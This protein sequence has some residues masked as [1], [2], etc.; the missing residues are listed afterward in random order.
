VHLLKEFAEIAKSFVVK[1]LFALY[2][3]QNHATNNDKV[4]PIWA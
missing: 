4:N 1:A 2:V 3:T